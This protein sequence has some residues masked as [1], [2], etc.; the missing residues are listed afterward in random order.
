MA[1]PRPRVP[2]PRLAPSRRPAG[3]PGRVPATRPGAAGPRLVA[4]CLISL[5]GAL[6]PVRAVSGDSTTIVVTDDVHLEGD[7]NDQGATNTGSWTTIQVGEVNG[8]TVGRRRA[9]LR[10]DLSSIPDNAVI[11]SATLRLYMAAAAGSAGD[12]I[13][14]YRLL[15]DWTESGATWETRD[16]AAAWGSL[17]ANGAGD[18][19][20][21]HLGYRGSYPNEAAGWKE[22]TL[23]ATS[24]AELDA[25]HGVLLRS[26]S[27]TNAEWHFYSSENGSL[28]PELVVVYSVPTSTPSATPTDTP[29]P[30][31]AT[32]TPVGPTDTPLPPTATD[33]SVA[34][35]ATDTPIPATATP[36]PTQTNTPSPCAT[37]SDD[38]YGVTLSSGNCLMVSRR[39]S[40]GEIYIALAGF[41]LAALFAARWL[42]DLVMRWL[43]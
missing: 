10:F 17:G 34:P 28:R 37:A 23:S 13:Y 33:T 36:V 7:G 30:P 38:E 15:T 29:L 35:P 8:A 3:R 39:A 9:L 21:D 32:D 25:G 31:T 14:V 2:F 4:A 1:C 26:G 11:T 5:L 6:A 42:Y 41:T 18:R 40:F 22:W 19:E 27:E 20:G 16:G 24:K 12:N 43:S